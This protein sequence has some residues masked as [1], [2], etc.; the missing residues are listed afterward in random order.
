[1]GLRDVVKRVLSAKSGAKDASKRIGGMRRSRMNAEA[2]ASH[3]KAARA[4]KPNSAE[5]VS[6]RNRA[7]ELVAASEKA[8]PYPSGRSN[9]K[10]IKARGLFR[11]GGR[12]LSTKNTP[13]G[14][15]DKGDVWSNPDSAVAGKEAKAFH[16][17][18][19][20]GV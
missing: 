13:F 20:F 15:Y 18:K 11:S 8:S 10:K 16:D 9:D 12:G 14:D 6:K 7:R 3:Y 2:A 17:P 4:A 1:M 5:R 19:T